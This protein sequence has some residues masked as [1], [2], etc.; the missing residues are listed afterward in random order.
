VAESF[1]RLKFLNEH[2]R[3]NVAC[4][5]YRSYGFS[6]GKAGFENIMSDGLAIY[7]F[8]LKNYGDESGKI[9]IYTQSV[10]TP[11]GLEV[12]CRRKVDGII[13]EA[14][15]TRGEDA[16][17]HMTDGQPGISRLLVHLKA[18]DFFANYPDPPVEKIK[19]MKAPLLYVL[20][21]Q[22]EV[23]PFAMGK[24]LFDAAGSKDKTFCPKDGKKHS[25]LDI[26]E[27]KYLV[28]TEKFFKARGI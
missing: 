7:D 22:D 12:A 11:V 24:E 25:N 8:V 19:R 28:E 15:F 4:F 23:F 18:D 5:D 9:F 26:T 20:G 3:H 13:M 2:Y 16:V 17:E 21:T 10:G 1:A 14:G 6:T 27:G